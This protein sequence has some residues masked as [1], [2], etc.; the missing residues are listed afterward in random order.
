M[1]CKLTVNWKAMGMTAKSRSIS[2]PMPSRCCRGC[3]GSFRCSNIGCWALIKEASPMNTSKTTSTN[4]RSVSIGAPRPREE[5][6]STVWPNRPFRSRQFRSTRLRTT[7][8]SVRWSH[9][10]T[11]KRECGTMGRSPCLRKQKTP[12]ATRQAPHSLQGKDKVRESCLARASSCRQIMNQKN[13][14]NS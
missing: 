11:P 13:W 8:C 14:T 5:S 6:G 3:I 2:R 9:V 10:N 12:S 4:S 1:A 7:R